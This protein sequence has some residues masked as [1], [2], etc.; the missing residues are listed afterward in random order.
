MC[1]WLRLLGDLLFI[2]CGILPVLYLAVRMF[3]GRGRYGRVSE[4]AEAEGLVEA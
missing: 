4:G 3:R 2:I 1:E